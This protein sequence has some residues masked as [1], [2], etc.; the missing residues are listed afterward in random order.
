VRRVPFHEFL[1]AFPIGAVKEVVEGGIVDKDGIQLGAM[2]VE[3]QLTSMLVSV[4]RER[5]YP[6]CN[7]LKDLHELGQLKGSTLRWAKGNGPCKWLLVVC[8]WR[9]RP[10]VDISPDEWR[11]KGVKDPGDE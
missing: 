6:R 7:P 10:Q 5:P 8:I 3:H 9:G 4:N 1:T 2:L 11:E